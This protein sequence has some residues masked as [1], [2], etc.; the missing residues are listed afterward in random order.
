MLLYK[1]IDPSTPSQVTSTSREVFTE[2]GLYQLIIK[3]YTDNNYKLTP[4]NYN[5]DLQNYIDEYNKS[6][7][8]SPSSSP[9]KPITPP[10]LP[11]LPPK[12][13]AS[14]PNPSKPSSPPLSST[15]LTK[16]DNI[17]D[18]PIN[19]NGSI[20]N[21]MDIVLLHQEA[22]FKELT[23]L[24]QN[25]K[26]RVIYIPGQKN[27]G[28]FEYLINIGTGFAATQ[29]YTESNT[30][31]ENV[32]LNPSYTAFIYSTDKYGISFNTGATNIFSQKV[33]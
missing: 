22:R 1:C 25:D 11:S 33:E 15:T 2:D 17:F 10:N 31:I 4:L 5:F 28:L 27:D 3:T 29:W 26:N 6:K 32:N 19:F 9:P 12:P 7:S 20:P 30:K 13:T 16:L 14:S 24:L 23:E 21:Y 8:S 18:K